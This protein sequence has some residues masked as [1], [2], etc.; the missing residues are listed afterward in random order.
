MSRMRPLS[1]ALATAL[2]GLAAC[3]DSTSP[4]TFFLDAAFSTATAGYGEVSSSFAASDAGG[5]PWQPERGR[6]GPRNFGGPGGPGMR[7]IMGGGLDGNFLGA[8]GFGRGPDRGPFAARDTTGCTF[9]A[10]TGD[11]T[12]GPYTRGGLTVTRVLTYKNAAGT[13]QSALDSTTST[14]R[15]R[16][17][18]NGTVQRRDSVTATVQN[19]SDRTVTGLHAGST[20]RTV[21]G[22]SSGAES[23][24]GTTR[25]GKTFSAQRT[26]GDTTTG[27]TIPL[28]NGRPTYPTAGSVVRSMRV[29]MTVDGESRTSTRREVITYNGS[30]TATLVITHDGNTKT[31]TLPLPVGRPVCE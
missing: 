10:A 28:E 27:L 16:I 14:A 25:D 6:G 7:G 26:V 11:I 18:A 21:N 22:T 8:V 19:S 31:C 20:L 23:A 4:D 24:S 2:V 29:V 13:A 9:S 15:T 30:A 17:T 5:L 1:L 3:N 12:C